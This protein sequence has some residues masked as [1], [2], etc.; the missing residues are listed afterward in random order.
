MKREEKTYIREALNCL[1]EVKKSLAVQSNL[2]KYYKCDSPGTKNAFE[3]TE[4]I[5]KAIEYFKGLLDN[6]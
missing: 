1:R 4:K 5:N 3:R 6:G 2:W